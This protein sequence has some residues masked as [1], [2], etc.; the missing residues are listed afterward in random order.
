MSLSGHVDPALELRDPDFLLIAQKSCSQTPCTYSL[1]ITLPKSGS[2]T[3]F[4]SDLNTDDPGDYLLQLERI[5]PV[6][7]SVHLNYDSSESDRIDPQ[8]DIDFFTFNVTAGTEIRLNVQSLTTH[9]DPTVEIRDPNG[10]VILNG[11]ADGASCNQ[12]PCTFSVDLPPLTLSG[13]YSLLLYDLS[14]NDIGDYNIGLQCFGSCGDTAVSVCGD[15]CIDVSNGP[16]T[17]GID[18]ANIQRDTDGDDYGNMCDGDLNND[19]D[20]N[21]LDLNL[22]K[23]AHRTACGDPSYNPDADFNGDCQ[24]NTLDLNIYKGLHRKP[25]GPSCA[26]AP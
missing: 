2:Y 12:T 14:T 23:L 22:Y 3:L 16:L 5:Q 24:I 7:T 11:L 4:M 1:D 26:V 6:P 20:T 10:T 17:P 9:V 19:G 15:N 8:S 21:T 18:P 13:N 25:P